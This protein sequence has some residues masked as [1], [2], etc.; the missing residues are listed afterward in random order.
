MGIC[1]ALNTPGPRPAGVGL[2]QPAVRLRLGHCGSSLCPSPH[3]VPAPAL[4]PVNV[5]HLFLLKYI[6]KCNRQTADVTQKKEIKSKDERKGGV[7]SQVPWEQRQ[8]MQRHWSLGLAFQMSLPP[9]A[10]LRN[11]IV[12]TPLMRVNR[13][14]CIISPPVGWNPEGRWQCSRELKSTDSGGGGYGV[15]SPSAT[16]QLCDLHKLLNLSML[17]PLTYQMRIMTTTPCRGVVQIQ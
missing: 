3:T 16:R 12:A 2:H 9:M 17:R 15:E 8:H 6:S 7:S 11:V 1:G 4:K 13:V 5:C 10:H 14:P